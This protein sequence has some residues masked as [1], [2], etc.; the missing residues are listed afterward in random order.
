MRAHLNLVRVFGGVTGAAFGLSGCGDGDDAGPA[1]DIAGH[2]TIAVTNRDNGCDFADFTPSES[3]ESIPLT[4]TQNGSEVTGTL[5][6]LAGAWVALLFGSNQF[7][8]KVSGTSVSMTLYGNRTATQGNCVYSVNAIMTATSTGDV[9]Q[10]HIDYTKAGNSNPD[11]AGVSG[12]ITRQ[13][14]NGTR[15]PS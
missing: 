5:E 8:G 7:T 15:P 9:L 14:F 2:Y 3:A 1:A 6:G 4:I 13:D 12:C 10:G 11:C